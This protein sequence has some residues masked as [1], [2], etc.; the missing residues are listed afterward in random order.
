MKYAA[1][2]CITENELLTRLGFKPD[3]SVI[4][5]MDFNAETGEIEVLIR[6]TE[7]NDITIESEHSSIRRRK[8]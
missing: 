6:S 1:K 3:T 5:K 8:L 2:F 7:P 4:K